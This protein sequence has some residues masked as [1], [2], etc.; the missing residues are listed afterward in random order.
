MFGIFAIII[1]IVCWFI[2][3]GR[4]TSDNAYLKRQSFDPFVYRDTKG[5]MHLKSNNQ[6]VYDFRAPW[7]NHVYIR[8]KKG[9]F[10]M[11]ETEEKAKLKAKQN[12]GQPVEYTT[13]L[14]GGHTIKRYIV[15]K[16]NDT[17][18]YYT[19]IHYKNADLWVNLDTLKVERPTDNQLRFELMCKQMG[20]RYYTE[21]GFR[22]MIREFNMK[23]EIDRSGLIGD[24]NTCVHNGIG[25][26]YWNNF[27]Y[28]S[29]KPEA[30]KDRGWIR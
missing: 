14:L 2:R 9:N 12:G 8:D 3:T 13:V 18:G 25:G 20:Y 7:N 28:N 6:I 21:E 22:D 1:Y 27:R 11:D 29:R 24:Y 16:K 5:R 4:E 19:I 17:L 10:I 30:C 15:Q 26:S 23:D